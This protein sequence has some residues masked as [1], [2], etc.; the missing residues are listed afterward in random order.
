MLLSACDGGAWSTAVPDW[1]EESIDGAVEVIARTSDG[2]TLA[3]EHTLVQPFVNEK[4]DSTAFM[5]AFGR[6]DR[7]P[8][9][10]LPERHLE[11]ILPVHAIPNGYRW[12][13]VGADLLAWLTA[14]HTVAPSE[15]ASNHKVAVCCGSKKGP[16]EL[17]I[18]LQ[19]MHIPGNPGNCSIARKDMP[20]DLGTVVE[21]ALRTKVTK[22]AHT[23]ADKR[24]LLLE[25][26]Q[27]PFS[28]FQIYEEI[29]RLAPSFPDLGDIQ[30]LWFVNTSILP[31]EGWA[32]F[33]LLDGRGL[34]EL[35]TFEGGVLTARRDDRPELGPAWRQF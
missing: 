9:L 24:I 15:G 20:K 1:I 27:V 21:K 12:A 28:E 3:I 34:V 25:K 16:L 4:L 23:P 30:E 26:E 18:T 29:V 6:I 22:L 13:D 35:L 10:V 2:A 33:S 31:T 17:D 11:V 32:S 7:N 14:N 8:A 5:E 19:T